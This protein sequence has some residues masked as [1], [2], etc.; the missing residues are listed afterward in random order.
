MHG[1]VVGLDVSGRY[2]A[3]RIPEDLFGSS[4]TLG[5]STELDLNA[6]SREMAAWIG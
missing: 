3:L 1:Q 6:L 2:T 4:P 5:Y